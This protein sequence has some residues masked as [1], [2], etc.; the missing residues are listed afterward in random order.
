[1]VVGKLITIAQFTELYKL[2]ATIINEAI[3]CEVNTTDE[4]IDNVTKATQ[5][6]YDFIINDIGI[7]PL[8]KS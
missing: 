4:T 8:T 1:M 7:E 5:E 2:T 3:R 6:Y